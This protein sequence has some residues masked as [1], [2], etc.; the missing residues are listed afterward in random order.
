[1]ENES[2]T[3]NIFS[4]IIR[5]FIGDNKEQINRETNEEKDNKKTFINTQSIKDDLLE[6][7]YENVQKR[8]KELEKL[9][10]I[11]FLL[12]VDNYLSNQFWDEKI[13]NIF[14]ENFQ[15]IYMSKLQ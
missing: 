4:Y 3:S 10:I 12:F 8:F 6:S 1:M 2:I 14:E 15:N 11:K 7:I 5:C 9:D 13:S